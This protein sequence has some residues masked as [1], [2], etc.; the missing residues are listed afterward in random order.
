MFPLI[1]VPTRASEILFAPP[2]PMADPSVAFTAAPPRA[3]T[4]MA[5]PERPATRANDTADVIFFT[6]S[7]SRPLV[8]LGRFISKG[9]SP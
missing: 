7:P 3:K 9:M 8:A 2:A 4:F 6:T 5:S 1:V